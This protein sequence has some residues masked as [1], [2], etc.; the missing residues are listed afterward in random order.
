MDH[1][2]NVFIQTSSLVI[3]KRDNPMYYEHAHFGSLQNR[4]PKS[5]EEF[6]FAGSIIV[7]AEYITKLEVDYAL[8]KKVESEVER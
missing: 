8:S 6:E 2:L 4:L 3:K 5:S 7:G 1:K